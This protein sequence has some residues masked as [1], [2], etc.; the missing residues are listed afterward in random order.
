[1]SFERTSEGIS[2][3]HL[4]HSVDFVVYVE[5]KYEENNNDLVSH[6]QYFWRSV[7][8]AVLPERTFKFISRGSKVALLPIAT[9]IIS[10]D[11]SNTLV[12][13]D[14]DYDF[15]C[16]DSLSHPRIIYTYGYS[17]ENDAWNSE[18]IMRLVDELYIG[19]KIH[20][21]NIDDMERC[22]SDFCRKARQVARINLAAKQNGFEHVIT[23]SQ[24]RG[25]VEL[26][27][28]QLPRF[29]RNCFRAFVARSNVVRPI[30]MSTKVKLTDGHIQGH[31]LAHFGYHF[32]C[33]ALSLLGYKGTICINHLSTL[34][35]NFL[36]DSLQNIQDARFVYYK[37]IFSNAVT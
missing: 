10:G 12:A 16:N 21:G 27:G 1:M 2:N 24:M 34:A 3:A 37:N 30:L 28:N 19:D 14:R 18:S 15:E 22:I 33:R 6:D 8:E 29:N 25:L 36:R 5:G 31:L 35:I 9:E 11:I 20:P 23:S 17:W 26:N 32:V 7:A 13:L 4:F